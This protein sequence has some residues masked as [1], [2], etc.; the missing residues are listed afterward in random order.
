[1][2]R[3]CLSLL[4]GLA[5]TACQGPVDAAPGIVFTDVTGASGIVFE[6][7]SGVRGQRF[8]LQEIMGSGAALF[9]YDRDGD[10]DIYLVNSVGENRLYRQTRALHFEDATAA[11]GLADRGYGMG[12]AVGDYDSDG[13]ID[14]LVTNL[15]A[16]HL[17]RNDGRGAFT[18]VTADAGIDSPSWSMSAAFCDIDDDGHLDLYIAAYVTNDPPFACSDEAGRPDYCG[19]NVY[20]GVAD[21][22]YRNDGDGT[23][24]DIS[25][26]SGISGAARNGLGVVCFDFNGDARDDVLVANDGEENLLWINQ[27]DGRFRDEALE[28]GV[29]VNLFG[30]TEASMGIALGD[31]D[32]D[33]LLDVLMT[34]LDGET[35]TL[36]R[37]MPG[38]ALMDATAA[39]GI[40]V[41]SMAE[42]GFGTEFLDADHD[43]D[44]DLAVV[45]GHVRRTPSTGVGGM[46]ADPFLAVYGEANLLLE[47]T[48][49][50]YAPGCADAAFC[51][52]ALVSRGLVAGD[53]DADGD[54][55]LLV[56]NSNGP[57]RLFRNDRTQGHW[58]AVRVREAGRDAV[59]SLVR[60]RSGGAWRAR[61]VLHTR[62]Y[63]SSGDAEVHFGLGFAESVDEIVVVWP[64]GSSERFAGT[65]TNRRI[66]L[67]R[68]SGSE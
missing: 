16:D 23:F 38:G 4:A 5:T 60:V 68:G 47:N 62:S 12:A 21:L 30:E 40:G 55:D 58:L 18:E 9:D 19:P 49:G 64:D 24:T 46:G 32:G 51:R 54:L 53:I 1:M 27:G 42:T 28:F 66:V 45:N 65:A 43:G 8:H 52:D 35:H 67:V 41:P 39:S 57:A 29:S 26:S 33:G 63:L 59:G 2:S 10:L 15:G 36:Y 34:H 37:G 61:P 20:R 14:L 17:Y 22:L 7:D 6:H 50:R 48:G 56:T 25:V 13:D 11:S 44:L 31:A 3:S